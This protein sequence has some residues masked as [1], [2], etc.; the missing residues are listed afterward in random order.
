MLNPEKT[1]IVGSQLT[2]EIMFGNLNNMVT[3][4]TNEWSEKCEMVEK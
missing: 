3:C 1:V 2:S 4:W